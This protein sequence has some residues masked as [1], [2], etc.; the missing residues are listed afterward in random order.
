MCES[1]RG[2]WSFLRATIFG[3]AVFHVPNG[4]EKNGLVHLSIIALF[5][6]AK[7][8][9]DACFFFIQHR[10]T[11]IVRTLFWIRNVCMGLKKSILTHTHTYALKEN[12][13]GAG[14]KALWFLKEVSR[15]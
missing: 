10:R 2:K 8:S 6:E 12:V 15:I 7:L 14:S 11:W 4:T 13:Q 9:S 5:F 3:R 1:A